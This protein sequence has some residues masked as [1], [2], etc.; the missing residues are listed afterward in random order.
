MWSLVKYTTKPLKIE[1]EIKGNRLTLA[2]N[3]LIISEFTSTS[4]SQQ[5]EATT[6]VVIS[7]TF[8]VT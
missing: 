3:M 7:F 1:C 2:S 5:V 4:F 8:C 6:A